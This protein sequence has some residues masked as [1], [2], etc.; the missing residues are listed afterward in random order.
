MDTICFAAALFLIVVLLVAT[1]K[2]KPR[3][4]QKPHAV[5]VRCGDRGKEQAHY[6]EEYWTP[7]HVEFLEEDAPFLKGWA[8]GVDAALA[9][10]HD[11]SFGEAATSA[12]VDEV[13]RKSKRRY[14]VLQNVYI[15]THRGYTEI[16]TVLLHETGI[17]VFE[18][19][20]ISG[21]ISGELGEER[22]EQ[23]LGEVTRHTLYNPVRQN[24]GH[25]GALLRHLEIHLSNAVIYS[26]VVFSDRCTL[27]RVPAVGEFG[28]YGNGW[29]IVH[30]GELREALAQ[31]MRQRE[32]VFLAK[33]VDKWFK[34]LRPCVEVGNSV[35]R[36][37]SKSLKK[38]YGKR[39]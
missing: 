37:H 20:N 11:G 18:T 15:A 14:H 38:M 1:R 28:N 9:Y 2:R 23:H 32:P 33:Q 30:Y 34:Q 5:Q 6:G 7:T 13:A 16:D 22:W 29:R 17:Y 4:K 26:F 39:G 25:M 10:D 19:K 12:I 31:A 36:A 27:R 3:E 35:R 8:V 24:Q 21:E